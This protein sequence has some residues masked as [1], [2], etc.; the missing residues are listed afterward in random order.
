MRT[1]AKNLQR[2]PGVHDVFVH[3]WTPGF[4]RQNAAG[5]WLTMSAR[6]VAR[7]IRRTSGWKP[8]MPIRLFSCYSARAGSAGALAREL[9][10]WV[11][12][13]SK[14]IWIDSAGRVLHDPGG[15]T[16]LFDPNG[17][18]RFVIRNGQKIPLAVP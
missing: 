2:I 4:I 14:K 11:Y 18:A 5:Q 9:K 15:V 10:T 8:G 1:N 3:G 16:V 13:P 12:A 7:V 6:R 17:I